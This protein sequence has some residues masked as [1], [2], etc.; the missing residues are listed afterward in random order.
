MYVLGASGGQSTPQPLHFASLL[1]NGRNWG[2]EQQGTYAR[3]PTRTQLLNLICKIKVLGY[4]TTGPLQL[5]CLGHYLLRELAP[6]APGWGR[7][8]L[9]SLISNQPLWFPGQEVCK[10]LIASQLPGLIHFMVYVRWEF[11]F[12]FLSFPP[13]FLFLHIHSSF[14]SVPAL[15]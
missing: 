5:E 6:L 15:C 13:P 12:L 8:G 14:D 9:S 1:F 2:P 10:T 4:G 11:S 7:P 3:V